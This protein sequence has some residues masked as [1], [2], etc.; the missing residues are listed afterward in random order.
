MDQVIPKLGAACYAVT[1]MYHV[2][3]AD[4][5]RMIYFG[6]FHSVMDMG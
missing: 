4:A 1:M 5:F 6:Y 2:M 3:S